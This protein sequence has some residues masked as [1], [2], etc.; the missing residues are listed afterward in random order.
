MI[1]EI[2]YQGKPHAVAAKMKLDRSG[3]FPVAR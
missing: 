3:L 1:R 2:T